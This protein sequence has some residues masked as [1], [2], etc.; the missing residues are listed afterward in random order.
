MTGC[1]LP[2][3]ETSRGAANQQMGVTTHESTN[4]FNCL[5]YGK[6]DIARLLEAAKL[7]CHRLHHCQLQQIG[8]QERVGREMPPNHLAY[9]S[10]N[11]L[12]CFFAGNT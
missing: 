11:E 2:C 7:Q 10:W 4:L 8:R 3:T 5:H 6:A 9:W 1:C 12:L